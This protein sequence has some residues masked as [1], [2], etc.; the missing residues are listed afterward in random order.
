MESKLESFIDELR[1]LFVQE[2]KSGYQD[3]EFFSSR[4][5]D[6]IIAIL[7]DI[8]DAGLREMLKGVIDNFEDYYTLDVSNRARR[9]HLSVELVRGMKGLLELK[10]DVT[11]ING[12]GE[13][14]AILLN[15]LEIFT[16]EDLLYYFPY[17]HQD[18][19]SRKKISELALEEKVNIEGVVTWVGDVVRFRNGMSFLKVGI[20]D[21]SG[22]IYATLWRRDRWSLHYIRKDFSTANDII[23]TGKLGYY[24]N[25]PN[26]EVSDHKVLR[27]DAEDELLHIG[28]I[29]PQYHSSGSGPDE[30]TLR[31]IIK[32][33]VDEYGFLLPDMLPAPIRHRLDLVNFSQAVGNIHFP[34]TMEDAE[35]AHR[36][37]AFDE[38][39]L[40]EVGLGLRK[41]SVKERVEGIDFQINNEMLKKAK[42]LIP[43]QLTGAQERVVGEISEDMA[44]SRPMH[45]LLQGDVGSGKTA[46]ALISMLIAIENGYQ[47]AIMAPTEVLAEQHFS[48]IF[49]LIK[50]QRINVSLLIGSMA[51][52]EKDKTLERMRSGRTEIAVGTHALIQE[53]VD[54]FKLGFIVIDEQHKFGVVQR[55]ALL[56]KAQGGIFG[57][58]PDTLV[59]TATPIPR[60]L[61]MTVYGDLD[62]SVIDEMPPGRGPLTTK[63]ITDRP[64][65]RKELYKEVVEEIDL[66]RQ[67]Y[68]IC[69]LVEESEK[70]DI[71]AAVQEAERLTKDLPQ[72]RIGLLHGRMKGEEKEKTMRSFKNQDLQILV[73]TTVVEVGVDVPNATFMIVEHAERFGLAQL[74][75]LRGRI[76]RGEHPSKCILLTTDEEELTPEANKRM[77]VMIRTT[78]GFVIAEEDLAIRGPGELLGTRQS[79]M[80]ELKMANIVSD[81]ALLKDARR[82]AF[83]LLDT[84]PFLEKEE[85]Q[86]IRQNLFKNFARSLDLVDIG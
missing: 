72:Y 62:V 6:K 47:T 50:E 41:K 5:T 84:D 1:T 35:K 8:D 43:F 16:K 79:G 56:E 45:R 39:F 11:T 60:T 37:L 78:D 17:N 15:N 19:G 13:K 82:E 40:L 2:K 76:G 54:F 67:V 80:P 49:R 85:H 63:W 70:I 33:V 29:V 86:L 61:A 48:N 58:R 74:H 57:R 46:V 28:R 18:R 59:M 22:F 65:G 53:K 38:L 36:R 71:R 42:E 3:E 10:D 55:S 20:K 44:L 81:L 34:E 4:V 21:K 73:S 69:P 64:E 52:A 14:T 24:R 66:G 30:K 26:F 7:S 25:K 12:V 51:K 27:P 9:Y 75:Q 68:I 83:D 32:K 77:E 23:L 31:E